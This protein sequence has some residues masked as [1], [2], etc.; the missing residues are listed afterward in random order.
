MNDT[1]RWL[2]LRELLGYVANGTSESVT[3]CQD[4]ATNG[5]GLRV[6]KRAFYAESLDGV[7]LAAKVFCLRM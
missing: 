5:W 6:G 7:L 3:I 4:D 2:L 1:E